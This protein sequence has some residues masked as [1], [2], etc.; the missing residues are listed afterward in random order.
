LGIT[1]S[2]PDR[3]PH[4]K[5]EKESTMLT[6]TIFGIVV[7]ILLWIIFPEWLSIWKGLGI[8]ILGFIFDCIESRMA[9][10]ESDEIWS[11]SMRLPERR[12]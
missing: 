9:E 3:N 10:N 12:K 8:I 6:F 4:T 1:N 11:A 7:D 5:L 2:S